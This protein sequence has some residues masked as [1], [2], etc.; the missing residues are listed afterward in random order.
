MVTEEGWDDIQWGL[1]AAI[2]L[3]TCVWMVTEE[4]WD[5]L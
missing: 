4:G 2:S 1:V 5:E 3:Y